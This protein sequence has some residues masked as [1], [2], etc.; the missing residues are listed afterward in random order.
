MLKLPFAVLLFAGASLNAQETTSSP[1]DPFVKDKAKK[2]EASPDSH[3]NAGVVVQY[4]DVKRERWQQWLSANHVPV[5]ASPLRKEVESWLA[6]GDATL[7]ESSLVMGKP[8][9]RAKVESVRNLVYPVEFTPG[10]SDLPFPTVTETRNVGTTTETDL[11][12]ADGGVEV[13]YAPERVAYAGENPGRADEGV[14]EGDLRHPTF[15]IQKTTI[16]SKLDERSWALVGCETSLENSDT[17]QTLIFARPLLHRFNG[18][19]PGP[20]SGSQG[21]LTWSWLEVSHEVFNTSLMKLE[22]SSAWIGGGL[23]EELRNSAASVVEE[24]A[25]PFLSGKRAKTESIREMMFPTEWVEGKDGGLATHTRFST[26]TVGTA[27]EVDPVLGTTGGMLEL[28]MAPQ[29]VRYVGTDVFHRVLSGGEW[30]PNV[31]MPSFYTMQPTTRLSL[32]LDTAVLVAV[33]SPPDDK[34]W[35]DASRK[36]LLFVKFSR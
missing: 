27:V 28:N 2:T 7:A 19:T 25:Q 35:A 18:A 34:G 11:I 24:R 31:T 29:F 9:Q 12:E 13:N 10:K 8:G 22:D 17:H 1:V 14:L 23:H 20:E 5:D 30:K 26:R 4:I 15:A 6:A 32:P 33:M 36:V 3:L 21:M 16:T